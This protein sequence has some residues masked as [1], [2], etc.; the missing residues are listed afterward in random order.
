MEMQKA[1]KPF[2]SLMVEESLTKLKEMYMNSYPAAIKNK[3]YFYMKLLESNQ[4]ELVL[5]IGTE[6]TAKFYTN[7]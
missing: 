4:N 2:C 1:Q 3:R 6:K 5:V 7:Q